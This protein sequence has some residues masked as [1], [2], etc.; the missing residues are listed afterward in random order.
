MRSGK[1]LGILGILTV[2]LVLAGCASPPPVAQPL[3]PKSS[4]VTTAAT[5]TTTTVVVPKPKPKPKP[6]S[7]N[8]SNDGKN[9]C[10]IHSARKAGMNYVF[11]LDFAQLYTGAQATKEAAKDG[12]IAEDDY[13]IRNVNKK[14]RTIST[15]G[16]V[17]YIAHP[18]SNPSKSLY[19]RAS[20][21][22]TWYN[23]KKTFNDFPDGSLDQ[24]L[25]SQA[26]SGGGFFFTVKNGVIIRIEYFWC[27]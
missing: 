11:V 26:Q 14:L 24:T 21:L 13:Y 6:K 20:D 15:A 2:L 8:T 3:A 10:F 25:Y 12:Q 23:S 4:A 17:P 7:V 18:D 27:P 19:Y 22:Y 9:F 1:Y 5:E 16:N